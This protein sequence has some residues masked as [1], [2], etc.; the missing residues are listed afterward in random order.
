MGQSSHEAE[1]R[2]RD[3]T[4]PLERELAGLPELD[5]FAS[6][7]DRSAALRAVHR[8]IEDPYTVAYWVWVAVMVCV[9]VAAARLVGW[10]LKAVGTPAPFPAA[11][12]IVAGIGVYVGVYRL[13]IRWAARPELQREL[14]ERGRRVHPPAEQADDA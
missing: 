8:R 1:T 10:G 13:I 7:G 5:Q 3:E 9:A 12:G 11:V 6:E 14:A 2:G 4:P